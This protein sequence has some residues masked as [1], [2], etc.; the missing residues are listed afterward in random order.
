MTESAL[1]PGPANPQPL[2]FS[3]VHTAPAFDVANLLPPAASERLLQLRQRAKDS[4]A[5][6]PR[7][8][9]VRTA[10]MARIEAENA[11]KR[12]VSHPQDFGF[13]L[14]PDDRRVIEAQKLV[15][16]LTA[17]LERLK[18]LQEVRAAAWQSSSRALSACEGFLKDGRPGGTALVDWDG[19]EL[20][21]LKGEKGLLDAVENR[22]RK[23]REIRADLARI[24]AAPFPSAYCKERLREMVDQLAQRGGPDVTL[25]LEH[26]ADVV[27]PT[28]RVQV[29]VFNAQPGAV[30]YAEIP[31]MLAIEAW[32]NKEALIKRLEAE[33]DSNSDDSASLT[34]KARQKREAELMGDL[35]AAEYEEAALV[36]RGQSEGLPCEHRADC[37]P[38]AILQIR[39]ITTAATNGQEP[40]SWMHAWNIRGGQ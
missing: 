25:L 26:D 1:T 33:I 21:L 4:H 27:W 34:H 11:L 37:D 40:S 36:W 9:D 2:S 5:L 30:G 38:C 12:L 20:Q 23:V 13:N 35:R 32:R 28:L 8:E 16:K 15:D 14:K 6:V 7:F 31:D 19:P 3:G 29:Q 17:D 22:R 10:S 24:A 39:M 18:Q